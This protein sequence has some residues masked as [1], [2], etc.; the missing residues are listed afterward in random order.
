M[1]KFQFIVLLIL[2]GLVYVY[3]PYVQLWESIFRRSRSRSKVAE[4]RSKK[5][6]DEIGKELK[7]TQRH[8]V[9]PDTNP[10]TK[11]KIVLPEQTN[12]EKVTS[13]LEL[14]PIVFTNSDTLW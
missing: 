2:L 4:M 5:I 14:A 9:N 3:E 12:L 8:K 11:P 7:K 6:E 10:I 13:K 1:T